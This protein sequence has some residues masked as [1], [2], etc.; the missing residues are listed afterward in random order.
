MKRP[1]KDREIERLLDSAFDDAELTVNEDFLREA[2]ARFR[3]A[4]AETD[5][6]EHIYAKQNYSSRTENNREDAGLLRFRKRLYRSQI[7]RVFLVIVGLAG[8]G[9]GVV[10]IAKRTWL[11]GRS[12]SSLT[13]VLSGVLVIAYAIQSGRTGYLVRENRDQLGDLSAS[14]T[15]GIVRGHEHVHEVEAEVIRRAQEQLMTIDLWDH[16]RRS[17]NTE[18]FAAVQRAIDAWLTVSPDRRLRSSFAAA[19]ENWNQ[20]KEIMRSRVNHSNVMQRF[21]MENPLQ[22][23]VVLSE[24]EAVLSFPRHGS[25][26]SFA[27]HVR[28]PGVVLELWEMFNAQMWEGEGAECRDII[29]RRDI[30][31]VEH[32]IRSG[33]IGPRLFGRK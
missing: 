16:C 24:R 20:C 7:D 33:P 8:I 4:Q 9:L 17:S 13:V 11:D 29:S 27:I 5:G 21:F 3:L 12:I 28:S 19:S 32:L 26:R 18:A 30:D 22:L 1:G 15:V 6:L 31:E 14:L 23:D 2:R 10:S 25:D